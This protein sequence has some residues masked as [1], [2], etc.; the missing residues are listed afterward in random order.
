MCEKC[1][2]TYQDMFDTVV[3]MDYAETG[4]GKPYEAHLCIDCR[5]QLIEWMGLN[6]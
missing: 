1:G 3:Q 5:K 4:R 2:R 6:R